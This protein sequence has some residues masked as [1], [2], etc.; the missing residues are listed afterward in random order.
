M[1]GKL[2]KL[3]AL[4]DSVGY[5]TEAGDTMYA[6]KGDEFEVG[7][8]QVDRLRELGAAAP[9]RE[10]KKQLEAEADEAEPEQPADQG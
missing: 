3:V 2:V 4:L 10:A 9:P 5:R 8:E 1:A 7:E 6:S